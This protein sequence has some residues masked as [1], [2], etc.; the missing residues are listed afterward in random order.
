M[1]EYSQLGSKESAGYNSGGDR[2]R[3]FMNAYEEEF[4]ETLS[5]KEAKAMLAQLA[6]M[7]MLVMRPQ[8]LDSLRHKD[9]DIPMF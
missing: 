7:Y 2:L 8:P 5:P 4:K 9:G 1:K 6:Q 3:E